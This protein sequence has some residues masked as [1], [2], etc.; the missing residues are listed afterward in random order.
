MLHGMKLLGTGEIVP[1]D[2]KKLIEVYIRS[3]VFDI[4]TLIKETMHLE[5]REIC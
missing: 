1:Q 5:W 4:G 2:I 3:L